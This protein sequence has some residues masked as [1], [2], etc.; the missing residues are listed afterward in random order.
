MIITTI[1]GNVYSNATAATTI[2]AGT[3][4]VVCMATMQVE[5][6][7][8]IKSLSVVAAAPELYPA[9]V[10]AGAVTSLVGLLTHENT[11]CLYP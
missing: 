7:E 1:I 6:D 10:D 4:Y 9:L 3:L 8:S 11:V 2:I 5:L